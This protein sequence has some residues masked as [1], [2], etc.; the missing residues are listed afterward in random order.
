MERTFARWPTVVRAE[1]PEAYVR[2]LMVD[3][4][5]PDQRLGARPREWLRAMVPERPTPAEK[6]EDAAATTSCCGR[7][8]VRCPERQRAA[9]VL[10]YYEDLSESDAAD[11]LG[12][13]V[14][15][16]GS[17][18]HDAMRAL[19]RGLAATVQGGG[20]GM[21]LDN[22]LRAALAEQ[23]ARREGPAPDTAAIRAGGLAI[24][25]RRR[26]LVVASSVLAVLLVVAAGL[27]LAA[28][29]GRPVTRTSHRAR[30]PAL[31]PPRG[32]HGASPTRTGTAGRSS[33]E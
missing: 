30:R 2:R 12:W 1:S 29:C 7:S 32:C 25:R 3:A 16:V 4:V 33:S 11:V 13:A 10:R 8:S 18:T 26:R 6:E 23:A 20:R 22:E 19:R 17:Q 28:A 14:R 9:L 21:T 27:G 5:I 15:T 31:A 24:R